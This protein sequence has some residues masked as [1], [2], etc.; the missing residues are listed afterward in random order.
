MAT[1][2]VADAVAGRSSMRSFDYDAQGRLTSIAGG[3]RDV[4]VTHTEGHVHIVDG[5]D[6]FEYHLD[7]KG[8]VTSVQQGTDMTIRAERD[9]A[10]DIVALSDGY[11][12]VQFGRDAL[13]RI[14]D[15][16][17]AD[18]Q[19][20]RYFY[21]DLGNRRLSEYGDGGWASYQYDTAGNVTGVEVA[22]RDGTTH[23]WTVTVDMAAPVERIAYEGSAVIEVEHERVE[24]GPVGHV[25]ATPVERDGVGWSS[26]SAA[27]PTSASW[28]AESSV[29]MGARGLSGQPDYGVVA[30]DERVRLGDL[31]PLDT[32][33][34]DLRNA[35]KLLEV[36]S[37]LLE[38]TPAGEFDRLS[39]P[40]FQ[41]A[42]LRHDGLLRATMQRESGTTCTPE[43]DPGDP[44]TYASIEVGSVTEASEMM[45]GIWGVAYFTHSVDALICQEV[46]P[47]AVYRIVG[48]VFPVLNE[49]YFRSDVWPVGSCSAGTRSSA[50]KTRTESHERNHLAKRASVINGRQHARKDYCSMEGCER[51]L[52]VFKDILAREYGAEDARQSCHL[53]EFYR[54]EFVHGARCLS[55]SPQ[56]VEVATTRPHYGI[57]S[58]L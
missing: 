49:G 48:R 2:T 47:D 3:G 26:D 14:V 30:F 15:A 58:N 52:G 7:R 16:T 33:V 13:G 1:A 25:T 45:E 42:E 6:V 51:G 18:G 23:P 17:Y 53:D 57:C 38:G 44:P 54:G 5:D 10:G 22:A 50:N 34:V 21:D 37:A 35:R 12:A 39:N 4:S 40:V 32:G 8:R 46:C 36:A 19:T 24:Y 41:S 31:D 55:P 9:D 28:T 29:L 56:S 11:R 27:S 20:S 43:C